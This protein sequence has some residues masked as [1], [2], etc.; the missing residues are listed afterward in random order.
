[1]E[2]CN[3]TAEGL[4]QRAQRK[5]VKIQDLHRGLQGALQ[6]VATV[7][8]ALQGLMEQLTAT[9]TECGVLRGRV[10]AAEGR[11]VEVERVWEGR[12]GQ[13]QGALAELKEAYM[14]GI[15]GC[16]GEGDGASGWEKG[17]EM[18][19]SSVHILL[20]GYTAWVHAWGVDAVYSRDEMHWYLQN[21]SRC[22][23][24]NTSQCVRKR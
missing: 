21:A 1:M 10:A 2:G 6:E 19:T 20:L 4:A 18:T 7:Q 12:C 9:Q 15:V 17:G 24:S 8:G 3:H 16:V 5:S 13:L 22:T 14:Q 23:F 11:A